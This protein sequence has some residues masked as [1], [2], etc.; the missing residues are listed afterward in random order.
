MAG[1]ILIIFLLWRA[2]VETNSAAAMESIA[3]VAN[4]HIGGFVFFVLGLGL[5]LAGPFEQEERCRKLENCPS[6]RVHSRFLFT[7]DSFL[8][9]HFFFLLRDRESIMTITFPAENR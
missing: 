5:G 2:G 7:S 6:R 4:H 3:N 8:L 9:R 1:R